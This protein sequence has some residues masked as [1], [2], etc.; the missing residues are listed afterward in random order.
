MQARRTNT[1]IGRGRGT[2]ASDETSL[3]AVSA[4]AIR[5]HFSPRVDTLAA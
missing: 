5:A 2:K 1:G 3:Q 4:E